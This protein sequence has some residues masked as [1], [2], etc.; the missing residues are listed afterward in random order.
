ML[1]YPAK[2]DE[3][4]DENNQPEHNFGSSLA[5]QQNAIQ[6][7]FRWRDDGGPLLDVYP[8]LISAYARLKGLFST[9]MGIAQMKFILSFR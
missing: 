9:I 2:V 4:L 7:A 5:R 3:G 1:K 8:H 6:M